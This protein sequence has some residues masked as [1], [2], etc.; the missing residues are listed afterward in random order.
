MT[1]EGFGGTLKNVVSGDQAVQ[2]GSSQFPDTTSSQSLIHPLYNITTQQTS[3]SYFRFHTS[4][5]VS[6]PFQTRINPATVLYR[7]FGYIRLG[8]G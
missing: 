6:L 1:R 5:A 7:V 2:R 3:I 4:E 8:R